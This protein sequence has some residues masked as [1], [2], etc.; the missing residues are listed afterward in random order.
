MS[1]SALSPLHVGRASWQ[2]ELS[3]A[4]TRIDELVRDGLVPRDL[5][6]DELSRLRRHQ[7]RIP[8]AL[9]RRFDRKD[10]ARCPLYRQAVP[11]LG[12]VDPESLPPFATQASVELYGRVLPWHDDA[13]GDVARLAAPRLTHRYRHRALLHVTH[14]CALYCRYCFRKTSLDT[15]NDELYGG[16]LDEAL[17]YLRAHEEIEEV[18]LTGGDP[19]VLPNAAWRRL[20]AQLDT[21]AHL[22]VVRVHTRMP[23]VLPERFEPALAEVLSEARVQVMVACHVNHPA[24]WT[25]QAAAGLACLR[26]AGVTLLHQGVLLRGINDDADV[27]CRLFQ[28]A[29]AQGVLP[30]SLHHPDLSPHTWGYRVGIEHGRRLMGAL[31]GR[32]TGPA[33]PRYV[34]DVPFGHGKIDLMSHR[35]TR[36]GDVVD[37]QGV[38]AALWQVPLADTRD[39]CGADSSSTRY[40]D[41]WP[42]D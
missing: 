18:V 31:T 15:R 9:A 22:R 40:L 1:A 3:G 17:A 19:M 4:Y 13:I 39:V 2:T 6:A 37:E 34:L 25:E 28:D 8:Q 36:E 30:F 23:A 38:S 35:V 10:L 11:W 24:E 33:L 42:S 5:S 12:E 7:L 32:V 27:L 29:Y 21:V 26:Q 14:A 41:L 20:L 16:P